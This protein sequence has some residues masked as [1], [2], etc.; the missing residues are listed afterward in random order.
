[1]TAV[2][3]KTPAPLLGAV[4]TETLTVTDLSGDVATF[5]RMRAGGEWVVITSGCAGLDLPDT[6]AVL[7]FL[8]DAAGVERFIPGDGAS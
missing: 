2:R 4:P 6:L 5:D 7:S 3:S 8:A 1:M